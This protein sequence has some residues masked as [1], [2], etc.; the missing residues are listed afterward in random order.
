MTTPDGVRVRA[1][2]LLGVVAT[3]VCWALLTVWHH[4]GREV[5]QIPWVG[6]APLGLVLAA[7]LVA[8]W[9]V[10]RY[11]RAPDAA[12]AARHRVS[13]ERARG[14]LVAAQASALGGAALFGWYLANALVN[15]PNMD[16]ASV[17]S[18]LVRALV[19]AGA[20][21]LLVI[22]GMLAQ[23]WCRIPPGKDDD[24]QPPRGIS[25]ASD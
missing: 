1:L 17:R 18:L 24:R 16:V 7:V 2:L 5:P 21:V 15:V 19:H 9:Q 8:G 23:A 3:G 22:A 20:A 4:S 25:L 14:T 6:L 12:T 11:V 10:R 13:P